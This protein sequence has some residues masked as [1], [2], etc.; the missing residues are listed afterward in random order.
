MIYLDNAASTPIDERVKRK[1]VD[2]MDIY[3]NPSSIHQMGST[4]NNEIKTASLIISNFLNCS[5]DEIYYTNGATMSNNCAIQGFMKQDNTLLIIGNIEHNDIVEMADQYANYKIDI[6]KPFYDTL[7]YM[8]KILSK[9]FNILVSIQMANSESGQ[10]NNIKKIATICHRYQNCY[11]HT[12]ATQ[13]IPYFKID[14]QD[15][16]IDMLSMSGQKI[17]CIKGTG[18]LYVKNDVPIQKVIYGEQGLIGGTPSVPL[19]S[20]LGEAFNLLDDK[21][22]KV[23]IIKNNRDMILNNL[24]KL[25]FHLI[26]SNDR[27]PNNIYGY[28]DNIDGYVLMDYLNAN[29]N[30]CIGTGSACSTKSNEPSHVAMAYL[31]DRE[32]ADKCIRITVGEQNTKDDINMFNKVITGV[33]QTL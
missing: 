11:L 6:T 31:H 17:N 18:V 28:F 23:N 29:F 3:G 14:V 32:L 1:I 8:L 15:M 22:T 26:G 10:I 27:L 25:G 2:V 5:A 20:G 19:I 24:L 4:A 21:Y 12:D 7:D 9:H 33:M 16:G 13:Y 30:I